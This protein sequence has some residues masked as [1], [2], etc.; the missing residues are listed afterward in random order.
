[1]IIRPNAKSLAETARE[2]ECPHRKG[3][4][5]ALI[6]EALGWKHG[7][8]LPSCDRCHAMGPSTDQAAAYRLQIV[9]LTVSH[10]RPTLRSLPA[11]IRLAVIQRHSSTDQ[12]TRALEAQAST[13]GQPA[14]D[15]AQAIGGS[16]LAARIAA[17]VDADPEAV[18]WFN[19]P[20]DQREA[21][22]APEFRRARL[23]LDALQ[24]GTDQEL[25][26]A[27]A[28]DA[29][30]L[31]CTGLDANDQR[32]QPPCSQ[33]RDSGPS[34]LCS[35]CG[36]KAVMQGQGLDHAPPADIETRPDHVR[37]AFRLRLPV[38]LSKSL[39]CPLREAAFAKPQVP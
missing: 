5:C 14:I 22:T 35:A 30:I 20:L 3:G 16:G 18:E 32:A 7:L 10:L 37:R 8:D 36:C 4:G 9:T 11:P 23:M 31:A 26:D 24:A 2:M 13:L 33:F 19:L 28:T 29:R 39:T 38:L 17:I 12:A 21:I 27:A 1:M 34:P 15:A 25:T 6:S